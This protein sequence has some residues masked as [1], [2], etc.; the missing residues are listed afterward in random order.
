MK[1]KVQKNRDKSSTFVSFDV[2][3]LISLFD[4]VIKQQNGFC[5]E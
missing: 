5:G 4:D 2:N 3:E 1:I